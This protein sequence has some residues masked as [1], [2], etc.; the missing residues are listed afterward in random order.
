MQNNKLVKVVAAVIEKDGK[1]LVAQR[2]K[3]EFEGLWEFP[4]GKIENGET[5]QEALSRE[6]KEEFEINITINEHLITIEHEYSNF[7]LHM[8]CYICSTDNSD[9]SLHDHYAIKWINPF[10]KKINWV[11]ADIK[12]INAY[13]KYKEQD[14]K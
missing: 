6:I 8:S 11:P 9:F 14:A 7:H 1:I 3:G 12:V 4:G 13:N 5:E 2:N 10:E